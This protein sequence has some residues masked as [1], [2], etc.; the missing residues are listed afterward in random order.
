MSAAL[1]PGYLERIDLPLLSDHRRPGQLID[2]RTHARWRRACARRALTIAGARHEVMMET[3][4]LRALFW[5]AFDRTG[6]RDVGLTDDRHANA[7]DR[8]PPSSSPASPRARS[9]WACRRSRW[10]MMTFAVPLEDALAFMV[11]PS[12]A[13]NVWQAIYGRGFLQA[14]APFLGRWR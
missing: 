10:R 13:T 8:R 12:M 2:S 14:A 3:D 5:E 7:G 9:A 11:V 1:A 4:D 6:E